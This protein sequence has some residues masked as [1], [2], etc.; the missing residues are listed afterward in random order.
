MT[1]HNIHEYSLTIMFYHILKGMKIS[2]FN[3]PFKKCAVNIIYSQLIT[4]IV[5]IFIFFYIQN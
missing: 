4:K 1:I 3:H 2:N 5:Y